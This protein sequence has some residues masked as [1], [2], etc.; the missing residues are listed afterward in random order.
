MY[1][2]VKFD[3]DILL[4]IGATPDVKG[5]SGTTPL[6]DAERRLAYASDPEKKR[7]YEKVCHVLSV[8]WAH[9]DFTKC[10][11]SKQF[12]ELLFVIVSSPEWSF[13]LRANTVQFVY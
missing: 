6:Q 9:F 8:A 2:H 4:W 7:R 10:G 3:V 1:V 5:R 11:H 13:F 12:Q